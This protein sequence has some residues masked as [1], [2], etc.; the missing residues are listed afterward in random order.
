MLAVD[1][2]QI[3]HPHE[4]AHLAPDHRPRL[5]RVRPFPDAG[6]AIVFIHGIGGDPGNQWLLVREAQ[7][8]G[9][10]VYTMLYETWGHGA[11]E[12]AEGF[13]SELRGLAASGDDAITLVA[14]SL[15]ALTAKGTLD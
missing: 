13:A 1:L 15:G 10:R 3:V 11:G 12:N 5:V 9:M 2:E 7:A 6:P 14:H 4:L 8:R